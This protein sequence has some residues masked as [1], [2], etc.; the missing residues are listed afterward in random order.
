[1]VAALM[2]V[3]GGL[4]DDPVSHLLGEWFARHHHF[5]GAVLMVGFSFPPGPAGCTIFRGL[6]HWRPRTSKI[7]NGPTDPAIDETFRLGRTYLAAL[8]CFGLAFSLAS[9]CPSLPVFWRAGASSSPARACCARRGARRAGGKVFGEELAPVPACRY[10]QQCAPG[11]R[12]ATACAANRASAQGPAPSSRLHDVRELCSINDHRIAA[13][14]SSCSTSSSL[15]HIIEVQAPLVGS[16]RMYSVRPSRAWPSFS[17][18]L[19]HA[20]PR[21]PGVVACWPTFT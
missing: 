7:A 4:E 5:R 21:P 18:A 13:S 2:P 3:M 11:C 9:R 12:P 15:R 6:P 10:W 20:A 1:M 19:S 16:S 17:R 14:T 8:A